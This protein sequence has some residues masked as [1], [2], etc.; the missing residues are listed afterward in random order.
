MTDGPIPTETI[1]LNFDKIEWTPSSSI[2]V[3]RFAPVVRPSAG[4]VK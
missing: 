3:G 1:S 2:A 4:R